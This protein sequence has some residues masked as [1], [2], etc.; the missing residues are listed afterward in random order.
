MSFFQ[1]F[2]REAQGPLHRLL[3]MSGLGGASSAAMLATLNAGAQAADSGKVSYWAAAAFIIALLLFIKAQRFTLITVAVEIEAMIHKLRV[4]LL[5]LVRRSELLPLEA[6]AARKSSPPSPRTPQRS[7][8]ER[9][10]L[11]GRGTH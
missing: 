1:L 7:R 4:R 10:G 5:D 8:R 3:I 6:S 11:L 9:D 2:R